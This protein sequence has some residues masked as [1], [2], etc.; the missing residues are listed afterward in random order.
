MGFN[1]L[2]AWFNYFSP[3]LGFANI[4]RITNEHDP[5][6]GFARTGIAQLLNFG[7]GLADNLAADLN[8]FFRDVEVR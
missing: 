3:M 6:S 8:V 2:S 7:Q 1:P 5:C 4:A